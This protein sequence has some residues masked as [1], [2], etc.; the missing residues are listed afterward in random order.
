MADYLETIEDRP[1]FPSIEPGSLRPLFPAAP[2]EAPEPLAAILDD[3]RRLVEP[4]A[5]GWQHPGFLAYFA[6]DGVGCRDPRARC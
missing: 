6:D 4:N 2:P 3:Y 1:V 5:T